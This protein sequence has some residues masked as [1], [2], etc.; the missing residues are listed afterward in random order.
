MERLE[1][2]KMFSELSLLRKDTVW[3]TPNRVGGTSSGTFVFGVLEHLRSGKMA[4]TEGVCTRV[5]VG[6]LNL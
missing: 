6:S 2:A 3:R 1:Q 4:R 5:I